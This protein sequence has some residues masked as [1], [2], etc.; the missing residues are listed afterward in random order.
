MAVTQ[1][2]FDV[3]DYQLGARSRVRDLFLV[4]DD[5]ANGCNLFMQVQAIGSD[6]DVAGYWELRARY[7]DATTQV[8]A[9]SA[10]LNIDVPTTAEWLAWRTDDWIVHDAPTDATPFGSGPRAIALD[11]TKVLQQIELYFAP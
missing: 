2:E 1:F 4:Y 11:G 6:E 5:V 7:A 9:T 3:A 8:L 10:L